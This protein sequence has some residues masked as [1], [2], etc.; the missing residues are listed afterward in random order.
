M[1]ALYEI[2]F[3]KDG[4]FSHTQLGILFDLPTSEQLRQFRPV[5]L[6]LAPEGCL[7]APDQGTTKEQ[8]LQDNWKETEILI[9]P[10]RCQYSVRHGVRKQIKRQQYGLRHRIASTIHASMGQDLDSIVTKISEEDPD[11]ALWERE[12]VVVLLSRTHYANQ[13]HFVGDPD[14]T[15]AT[16]VRLLKKTSAYT[17]YMGYL[18]NNLCEGQPKND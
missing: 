16:L 10:D 2:T 4:K 13:I 12:Q 5:T 14:E 8:L 6:L 3:N 17:S 15:C 18:I 7:T 9:A 1:G 11:F